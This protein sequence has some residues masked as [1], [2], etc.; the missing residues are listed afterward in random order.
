MSVWP[1]PE[2]N[3][4][5]EGH[6]TFQLRAEPTFEEWDYTDK[7]GTPRTGRKIHL[8]VVGTN[9]AGEFNA[10]DNFPVWDKRYA[11]LCAALRVDHGADIRMAGA[12]FEADVKYEPDRKN[13][14]KSW[15]RIIN[16]VSANGGEPE[17]PEAASKGD[18]DDIPF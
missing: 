10:Q 1:K 12:T 14:T 7:N 5:P 9:D 13:P 17:F 6:Y 8:E 4:I 16:I 2:S 3:M 15:P 18:D 11:D